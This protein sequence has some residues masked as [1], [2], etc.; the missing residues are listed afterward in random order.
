MHARTAIGINDVNIGLEVEEMTEAGR[1]AEVGCLIHG[2]EADFILLLRLDISPSL[3]VG[4]SSC[5]ALPCNMGHVQNEES[6]NRLG[7]Q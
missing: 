2:S 4:T 1:M 5:L 7:A 6:E 3:C